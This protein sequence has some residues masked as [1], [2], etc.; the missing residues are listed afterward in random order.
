MHIYKTIF[1]AAVLIALAIPAQAKKCDWRI[2]GKFNVEHQLDEMEQKFGQKQ[3]LRNIQVKISGKT[4]SALP[5]GEWGTVR[6][7]SDGEFSLSKSK[8]CADR[9]FKVQVKFEDN[10]LEL[11]HEHSTI[12]TNKKVKWY[13]AWNSANLGNK[14]PPSRVDIDTLTFGRG[15]GIS[16]NHERADFQVYR[17][18]EMWT[19]YKLL[20]DVLEDFGPEYGFEGKL[21]A[22]YPHN[23]LLAGDAEA[24]YTNPITKVVYIHKDGNTDDFNMDTLIHEAAHR[25]FYTKFYG[26]GCLTWDLI[27][28][29]DT[30]DLAPNSCSAFHEGAADAFQQRFEFEQFGEEMELP[31][32]RARLAS[33]S[34]MAAA[35]PRPNLVERLDDGWTSI[36]MS[37]MNEGLGRLKFGS[38][39]EASGRARQ[40]SFLGTCSTPKVNLKRMIKIF[41]SNSEKGFFR[42]LTQDETR[43]GPFLARA[44]ALLANFDEDHAAAISAVHDSRLESEPSDFMCEAAEVVRGDK[45][46]DL[47][48][49]ITGPVTRP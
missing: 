40:G 21:I 7:N 3:P 47:S 30:H 26:E 48:D 39:D 10:E 8:S 17:H 20:I 38:A 35:V 27:L 23:S 19:V 13:E 41:L 16:G 36:F 6:T 28:T 22:K 45:P 33:G 34:G 1:S 4:G 46:R 37:M 42:D 12:P 49:R 5:W 31:D 18:A 44:D 24:S 14:K 2:T 11:R 43:M 25:L 32:N 15:A 29:F 9:Y